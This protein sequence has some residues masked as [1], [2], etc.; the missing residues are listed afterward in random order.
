MHVSCDEDTRIKTHTHS[1]FFSLFFY[2]SLWYLELLKQST[3][4]LRR[5]R[6]YLCL[7]SYW[8]MLIRPPGCWLFALPC[9]S[10]WWGR[11]SSLWLRIKAAPRRQCAAVWK[12]PLSW[13]LRSFTAR[14]SSTL[15]CWTS[16]VRLENSSDFVW[17]PCQRRRLS[18]VGFAVT[19]RDPAAVLRPLPALVQGVLPGAHHGPQDPVP[20]RDVHA[21]D[22]HRPHP[23]D[24]GSLHD[25]VSVARRI[26]AFFCDIKSSTFTDSSKHLLPFLILARFGCFFQNYVPQTPKI[27]IKLFSSFCNLSCQIIMI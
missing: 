21:L 15:T 4:S 10:T 18:H 23:G 26:L 14:V 2:A 25:G 5:R 13:T 20:H 6:Q 17:L 24:Q 1:F 11:C 27:G 9:S 12:V 7:M 8:L 19:C 22:P 3:G 16:A